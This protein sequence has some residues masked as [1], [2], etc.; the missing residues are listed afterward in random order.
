MGEVIV[1]N[2]ACFRVGFF[3]KKNVDSKNRRHHSQP[4]LISKSSAIK[5][6]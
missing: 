2:D 6:F 1:G 5:G 3:L 4:W